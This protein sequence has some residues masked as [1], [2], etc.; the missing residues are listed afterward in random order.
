M[1][2][3][4]YVNIKQGTDS[5]PI[6]SSG[7]T[8]PLTQLPFGMAAFCPQTVVQDHDKYESYYRRWFYNP[9]HKSTG[10][11][12]LARQPSPWIG[13][14][15]ALLFL[16]Q[17][18][19]L[20]SDPEERLSAFREV[21][22]KPYYIDM[23]IHRANCDFSLAPTERGAYMHLK[24]DTDKPRWFSIF[25]VDDEFQCDVDFKSGVV[26]GYTTQKSGDN[27]DDFKE[28]FL[29]KFPEGA[30]NP[31]GTEI[32]DEYC[33]LALNV[34]ETEIQFAISYIS[35][36]QALLNLSQDNCG[37]IENAKE[38]AEK[39]WE[40]RLSTIEIDAD[41]D[42][43]RT[44]YSCMY[45]VFLF[46]HKA[47]ELNEKGEPIHFVPHNGTV[48]DGLRYTDTGF[49]DTAR[50]QF[51]LLSIIAQKDYCEMLTAFLNEYRDSG[52][53]PRWLSF[54]E[55]G[56]MPS[57]L[58]DGILADAAVKGMLKDED[59]KTAFRGMLHH[60]TEESDCWQY[61]R[62]GAKD[63]C[64]LGYVPRGTEKETVNL[65]TDAAYGDWCIAQIA[66]M[67]GEK[68]IEAE[69][70]KRAKNY[71]NLFDA[72]TGFMRGRY[73]NGEWREGEFDPM[74][75]LN[76]YTEGSAWQNS[77]FV[78]HDI[79]GL[80][81]LYGGREKMLQKMDELFS[82]P[83]NFRLGDRLREIHEMTE[84]TQLSYGQCGINN[85][86]SFHIP[87]IY[88]EL[89]ETEKSRYYVQKMCREV[90]SA[91]DGGFPGDEDNGSMAA[92][93]IF[94]ALGFYPFCPGC[95]EYLNLG[96][97]IVKSA[98]ICGKTWNSQTLPDRIKQDVFK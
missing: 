23:H 29:L 4:D 16:P 79:K 36:R 93:Y 41:E 57:T 82:A 5:I 78:P 40:E 49:W 18:D 96:G 58:I 75:W 6:Y 20:K 1:K 25:R 91:S 48:A 98:K 65:T 55:R 9:R 50:T 12:R 10:G 47:Y 11:I 85:Q 54:G 77:F 66:A 24:F 7:N 68:E 2:Y 69:Y 14:Y 39:L 30:I 83:A 21:E 15:G 34:S 31:I 74:A 92:W 61:G 95:G 46:P 87:Y 45:R 76:D 80:A 28:Y 60:S 17:S 8:L 3:L 90:F 56:C 84:L 71:A 62:N 51:P 59:L 32:T 52:W 37:G 22:L 97:M 64:R 13:D 38:N 44:F 86:P 72:E 42:T 27:E 89:G 43:L 81:E 19:T 33:H 73:A 35:P 70:R 94:G 63:Y 53:L 67:L 88:A 26:T